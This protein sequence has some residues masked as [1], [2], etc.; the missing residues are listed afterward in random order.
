MNAFHALDIF[1]IQHNRPRRSALA[2]PDPPNVPDHV[3]VARLVAASP[4]KA[5]RP[6]EAIAM[7]RA[8]VVGFAL[9][10]S[11]IL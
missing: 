11:A 10:F 7:N 4:Q 6:V 8:R 5:G 9:R 1:G 2:R 3:H